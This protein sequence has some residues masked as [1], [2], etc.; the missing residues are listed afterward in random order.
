[1]PALSPTRRLFVG[2]VVVL[3]LLLAACGE[4]G[5]APDP[6]ASTPAPTSAPT[7][8][9]LSTPTTA[10]PCAP[11]PSLTA[12]ATS[13][14]PAE[15]ADR[16]ALATADPRLTATDFGI[17]IWM[18]GYGEVAAVAPD[19]PLL[20]ASNQKILTAMGA[21]ALLGPDTRFTTE[22]RL[23]PS[24]DLVLVAGGDP[25][26]AATGPHSLD[27]LA[28][29]VAAAGV[30]QVR[31]A[32]VVDESRHDSQRRAGAWEDWQVPEYAGT[33]SALMV[34]RNRYRRDDEFLADPA[35]ANA[36]LFRVFLGARGVTLTGATAHGTAST[37]G[38]AVTSVTS[39][40][41]RELVTNTLLY[42]DNMMAELLVKE[43]GVAVRDEGSTAAGLAAATA[44]L[45]DGLCLPLDGAADDGS[46]LSRS[47]LRSAREWRMLLQAAP[48]QPW[49][50]LLDGALPLAGRTGTLSGR[51]RGTAA[52]ANVRAK[53]GTIIGGTALT[54][55]GT[56][57]GGRPF[58]FSII[59]NGPAANG[60]EPAIDALVAL[61]AAD[62]S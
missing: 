57:A 22:V 18:E 62:A 31:G 41:V 43:I 5:A 44:A 28:A 51:F 54:G 56:T 53:T 15:L 50:P 33:M 39:A 4:S 13:P 7:T 35:L 58:V 37:D 11:D 24:G 61:V 29:G 60:N 55:Y 32:L 45:A 8:T 26:L 34:D 52:E 2:A 27:A 20:P 42:S 10:P 38:T 40:P 23:A 17:S 3:A 14:V 16:L 1:M 47:N 46:G 59:S 9:A 6:V 49:W 36:E 12:P 19:D 21:L 30:T 48:T 25:S